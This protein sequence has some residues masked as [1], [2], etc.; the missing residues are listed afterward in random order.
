V[1]T[2]PDVRA[3]K[4]DLVRSYDASAGERD[5]RGEPA[6][7]DAYRSEFASTLRE[8]RKTRVLEIGAGSGHSAAFFANDGFDVVAVDL[9]P[10][11]VERCRAKGLDARVADFSDLPFADGTFDAV[12]SMSCLM[13]APDEELPKSLSEMS[14]VLATGGIALVGMWGGDGRAGNLDDGVHDPPRFF[15]LRTDEQVRR[16]FGEVFAVESFESR[17]GDSDDSGDEHYQIVTMRKP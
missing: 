5:A 17:P 3:I 11:N 15:A 4:A 9:S 6:W 12:W 14:R 7:R 13:H 16:M 1:N 8:E 2:A 10:L